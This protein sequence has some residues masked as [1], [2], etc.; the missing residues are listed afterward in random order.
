MAHVLRAPLLTSS[1]QPLQGRI[2]MLI[3]LLR[4][5]AIATRRGFGYTLTGDG[6]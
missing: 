1:A 4:R 2:A 5:L 3:Y 6:A